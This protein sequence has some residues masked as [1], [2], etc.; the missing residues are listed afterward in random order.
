MLDTEKSRAGAGIALYDDAGL[1]DLVDNLEAAGRR[2]R[3]IEAI[4]Y[5]VGCEW[6][7]SEQGSDKA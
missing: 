4:L 1:N 2:Y 7:C 6:R 3:A 5:L